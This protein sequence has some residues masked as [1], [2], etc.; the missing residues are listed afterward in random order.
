MQSHNALANLNE[1]IPLLVGG[2]VQVGEHLSVVRLVSEF[3]LQPEM[4]VS[5][6]GVEKLNDM[7]MVKSLQNLDFLLKPRTHHGVV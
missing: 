2:V 5:F 6:A 1:A 3:R 7:P 4:T